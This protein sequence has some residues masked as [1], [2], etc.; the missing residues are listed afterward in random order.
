MQLLGVVNQPPPPEVSSGPELG[1]VPSPLKSTC[2][3]TNLGNASGGG[4]WPHPQHVCGCDRGGFSVAS[5]KPPSSTGQP[6]CLH[7][8]AHSSQQGYPLSWHQVSF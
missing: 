1:S 6:H 8:H 7:P 3:F 2:I 5:D 4:V